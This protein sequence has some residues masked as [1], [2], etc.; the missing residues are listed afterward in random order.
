MRLLN[1]QGVLFAIEQIFDAAA[2]TSTLGCYNLDIQS[3]KKVIPQFNANFQRQ[4]GSKERL[5]RLA[6]GFEAI[7]HSLAK[8]DDS[9]TAEWSVCNHSSTGLMARWVR[10]TSLTRVL[11]IF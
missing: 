5:V 10:S 3:L 6:N 7:H 4:S 2:N 8:N 9:E 1:P 11:A